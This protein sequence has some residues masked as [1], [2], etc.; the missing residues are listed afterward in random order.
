MP[1]ALTILVNSTDRFDDCWKPFFTLFA[2]YWPDCPYPIVLNTDT[3]SYSHPGLT[4]RAS[5]VAARGERLTWSE[6]LMRCLDGIDT[7]IILYLQEDFFLNCPVQGKPLAEFAQLMQTEGLDCIRL[8]ECDG[9]G[10]WTRSRY[11]GLWEVDQRAR[12]RIALQA[13]LW[14]RRTLRSHLRR[15]E[16]PWQ[17]EIFGSRRLRRSRDRILCVDRERYSGPG[18]EIFPYEPTGVVSG[19][20]KREAVVDLFARHGIEV[21][22]SARG[23]Y[24]PSVPAR[25]GPL[26]KRALD[27]ARSLV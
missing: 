13:G 5:R 12:Y 27:R 7:E 17:L 6:C 24:D 20:W 14:C 11:P 4:I 10:P 1:P 16:S 15:H 25:K 23:F 19:K 22:Y 18:K 3:K 8:M 26:L 9:A 21:D 2:A